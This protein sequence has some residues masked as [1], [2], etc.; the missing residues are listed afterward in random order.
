MSDTQS[1][2]AM[3]AVEGATPSQTPAQT[4]A[5]GPKPEQTEAPATSADDQLGDAGKRALTDE[6]SARKIAERE[7]DE[8]RTRVEELEN[9]S[10]S[11]TEKAVANARKE[12]EAAAEARYQTRIRASEVRAALQKAGMADPDPVLGAAEFAALKVSDGGV[13]GLEAAVS[14]FKTAHPSLFPPTKPSGDI[15]QGPRGA[16]ASADPGPGLARL[17]SVERNNTSRA[18]R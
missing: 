4:P 3:P 17:R 8:L 16:P 1:A 6:R 13:E 10:R 18:S 14:A 7:R 11:E 15:G 5:A 2:G 9:A 12:G